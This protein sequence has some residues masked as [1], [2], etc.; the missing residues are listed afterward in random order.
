MP[1]VSETS[2]RQHFEALERG[3]KS[4]VSELLADDFV[5]EWPQSGERIRGAEAC[6]AVAQSYPGGTPKIELRRVTG[7][8]DHW[9]LE[10]VVHYPDGSMYQLATL[11]EFQGGR[12]TRQTDCFAAPFPAPEWRAHLV[13]RAE[14]SPV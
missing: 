13:E 8:G 2:V 10:G 14:A 6:M 1:T 7:E 3:D 11:L 5:Q 9:A 12:I 4:A